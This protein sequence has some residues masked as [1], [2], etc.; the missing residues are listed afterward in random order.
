[1]SYKYANIIVDISHEKIDRPFQYIIPDELKN[2][3]EIGSHVNIPFGKGNKEIGGY[4][5]G[6]C[7]ETDYPADKLKQIIGMNPKSIKVE[8]RQIKLAYWMREHYGSTMI[9]ALKTVLPVKQTV[10]EVEVREV[11]LNISDEEAV[12]LIAEFAG[13]HQVAKVRLLEELRKSEQISYTMITTKLGVSAQTIRGMKDKGIIRIEKY[14]DYRDPIKLKTQNTLKPGLTEEQQFIVDSFCADFNAQKTKT[15][16]I[17]GVTGSGKTEVYMRMIEQVIESGRQAIVL[18]PEIS[19]TYQ[20]LTRFYGRFGSKV[21]VIHSRLSKGE[22]F[23]QFE[24]AKKG[25]ISV[26]IGPRTALFT[27]FPNLGLIVIDEEHEVSY[28]SDAMPKFH[29]RETAIE[30]AAMC[31]ASVVLG[32]ATPSME[33]FYR[34]QTGE[35][36]L[37]TLNQRV[38][39]AELATTEIVDLREELRAGNT[40]IFSNSLRSKIED[41]LRKK[42]QIMLFINRRGYAG[43]IS[44]RACGHVVKCPHCDVSLTEH[45]NGKLVCHYCGF[46]M[47]KVRNCPSCGSKHISGFKGGTEM[48]E[49]LLKK[50]FPTANVLRMDADTTRKKEDFDQI[51]QAF[52]NEEADILVGTQMIVKGHDFPKVTLV[53]ILAADLS[54][55]ASDY[56]APE[57]TFQLLTQA[58]GRAG[59]GRLS[60]EVVI[61]TYQPEHYAIRHAANQDYVSFYKDEIAYRDLMGYPPVAHMLAVLF[62]GKNEE[63]VEKVA[64]ALSERTKSWGNPKRLLVLG[65]GKASIGKINDLY[66]QVIYLKHSDEKLLIQAKDRMEKFMEINADKVRQINIYFDFDPVN[67]Y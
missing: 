31:N 12:E 36:Q 8:S 34:T 14:R 42:E 1:M 10:K 23:D 62:T 25:E 48:I 5:I 27:P 57:R 13:K 37:F 4:V 56:R 44:C 11:S 63:Q 46:E 33:A 30:I 6:L 38:K 29:A 15:Y 41:R 67:G 21:S 55:A 26:M 2:T 40:S 32:S 47:P 20:T 28:K 59:R 58:A 39:N 51:L 18:I 65:P 16:L 49:E 7:N 19:L 54:L 35:Y 50:D 22:R 52:S 66:R 3:I 24:R 61:Q 45:R 64:T 9:T 60:G 17:H 43:F 53:G